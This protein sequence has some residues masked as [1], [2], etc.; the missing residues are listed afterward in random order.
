M[1]TAE[2]G[3]AA[4]SQGPRTS[5]KLAGLAPW[6]DTASCIVDMY[7]NSSSSYSCLHTVEQVATLMHIDCEQSG[8]PS[9]MDLCQQQ[10]LRQGV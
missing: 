9:T 10:F 6:D 5:W 2:F 3:D 8:M 7:T 1:N 4:A